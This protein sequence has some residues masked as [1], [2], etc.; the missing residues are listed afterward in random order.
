MLLVPHI[1]VILFYTK[2]ILVSPEVAKGTEYNVMTDIWSLGVMAIE[3][4]E[5]E[6]PRLN[7]PPLKALFQISTQDPPELKEPDDWSDSFKDFLKC[8]LEKNVT[9]RKTAKELL[10]H[11]FIQNS[12]EL[13]FIYD[14]IK[15]IKTNTDQPKA[16]TLNDLMNE[17]SNDED[18]E[19]EE[20]GD[21]DD[22]VSVSDDDLS[23]SDGEII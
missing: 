12:I 2:H 13:T 19:E 3:I 4:A 14:Y 6:V 16:K 20:E 8:T 11:S 5:G 7:V 18:E 9:K 17:L 22:Q 21:E 23:G 10:N 1:G 15:R